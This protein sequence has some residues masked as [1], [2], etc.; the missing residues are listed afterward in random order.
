MQLLT[1]YGETIY[2]GETDCGKPA[3]A[4]LLQI[5]QDHPMESH[6]VLFCADHWKAL[7]HLPTE[8]ISLTDAEIDGLFK[9]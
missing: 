9:K 1:V 7:Q 4:M 8:S 6:Q 5:E 3:I 2:C